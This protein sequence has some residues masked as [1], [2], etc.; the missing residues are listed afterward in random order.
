[1]IEPPKV[2]RWKMRLLVAAVALAVLIGGGYLALVFGFPPERVAA[3]AAEQVTAR[4]GRDFRIDGKLS[5]RVLPRIA[6]VADG[7]ALGNAPWGSR[8]E[9]LR[10]AHAAFELELWPL[11]QGDIK[12]GKVE[13]DGVDLLLE[14]DRQGVGNWVLAR[15]EQ[16]ASEPPGGR[17]ASRS[18]SNSIALDAV[19]L[20]DVTITY[21]DHRD[22]GAPQTLALNKLDLDR[23]GTG[24]R[25]V[26]N[27]TMQRQNWRASGQ[28]GAID[29]LLADAGDWPFDLELTTDGA[30]IAAR[31]T[32]LH[33]ISPRSA[34]LELDAKLDKP[35]ALAPWTPDAGRL[36]LPI[37]IKSTLIAS[38]ATV[39]AEPLRISIAGQALAGRAAW[40][41]GD[42]SQLDAKF[43]AGTIDLASVRPNAS[44][45]GGGSSASGGK[46]RDLFGDDKLPFA[47]LPNVN[48]KVGLRIEL[49]RLPSAPP[50][51]AVTANLN[52]NAGV[53][54]VE[55]LAFG[56]AGGTVRAS[57][58]LN[59]GAAPHL[60]AQVDASGLSAETLARAAGDAHVRGGRVRLKTALAMTGDTPRALAASADGDVL[61][62]VKDMTLAEG[63]LPSGPNLLPRL[64]QILQPQ[65]GVA[66]ATT[67]ECAVVRL[68]LKN[69]VASVERSIA[70]ETSDLTFSASGRIDLRDQ[71]LE[72]AIRPDTRKALGLNA[73][74]LAS[75]VV[76]KGP[77]RDPKLAI[78]S[79]AAANLALSIGAA[80]ATGGW[81]VLGKNLARPASDPHPCVYAETG[82]AA[83]APAQSGANSAGAKDGAP[84]PGVKPDDLRKLLRGIFK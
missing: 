60:N 27:W 7:L 57:V 43:E 78:D 67:V 69:G 39:K 44:A 48:A 40:R 65:R 20:R 26:A 17:G 58:A 61:V 33:G 45:G 29:T 3:L 19:R 22:R 8:K 52:L 76:A 34:R 64:M 59:S 79:G 21:L 55:P 56:V 2:S 35:G 81:S 54:R 31:G 16:G 18:N 37:E 1:M 24:S 6:V 36:P 13:L 51:S 9:M 23:D 5:W 75:L 38:S 12:V 32:L 15:G 83:K 62:S 68:P 28:L 71:T 30:R 25:I 50:L 42:P 74:Q 47:D 73:A 14:T 63:A 77:L 46:S 80:A 10:V 53:L 11:L 4:T 49:L 66:K 82:V 84:A 72:L 41:S 70:A